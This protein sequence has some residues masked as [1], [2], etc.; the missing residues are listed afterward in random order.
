MTEKIP[1]NTLRKLQAVVRRIEDAAS[2]DCTV[3][4]SFSELVAVEK[5][6]RDAGMSRRNL[7]EWFKK[8]TGM[9]VAKYANRRR[10]EYAARILRCFPSASNAD[11]SRVVGFAYPNALYYFMRRHG[12]KTLDSLRRR[13]EVDHGL[14]R[15]G[16]R[17]DSIPDCILFFKLSEGDYTECGSEQFERDNWDEIE[18]HVTE[19]FG[20][21]ARLVGYVGIAI[22]RFLDGDAEMGVFASGVLYHDFMPAVMLKD[23]AGSIGWRKIPARRYAVFTH[24]GSYE[25]LPM[26]YE[27]I[28]SILHFSASELNV[29]IASPFMELYLNSPTDTVSDLLE[30]ELWVPLNQG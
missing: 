28:L 22:D 26:F 13:P 3:D 15:Q 23:T 12:V 21:M 29:D 9:S 17:I 4:N 2:T 27:R 18:R 16:W 11:I 6:A 14:V 20:D 10:A 8:L 19:R 5:L 7:S 25:M 1:E 30:T 24:R